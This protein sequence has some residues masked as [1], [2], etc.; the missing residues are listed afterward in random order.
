M[1]I[2]VALMSPVV[3]ITTVVDH[4]AKETIRSVGRGVSISTVCAI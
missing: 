3:D 4:Y 2:L 1:C